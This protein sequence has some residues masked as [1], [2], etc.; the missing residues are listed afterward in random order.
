MAFIDTNKAEPHLI[1]LAK[2]TRTELKAYALA[3]I[4]SNDNKE[5]TAVMVREV[6]ES[7]IDGLPNLIDDN[8]DL[9]AYQIES[10]TLADCTLNAGVYTYTLAHEAVN[11]NDDSELTWEGIVCDYGA[12]YDISGTAL[13]FSIDADVTQTAD[14]EFTIKYRYFL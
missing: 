2:K 6:I 4:Y 12:E 11:P 1:P 10:F 5:V 14:L 7:L 3:R 9:R 13:T 8:L